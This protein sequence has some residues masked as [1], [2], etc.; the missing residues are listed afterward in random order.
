MKRLTLIISIIGC[1]LP[2]YV[3]GTVIRVPEDHPTIQSGITA[4]ENGN[5]VLVNT[6]VYAGT[7]NRNLTFEGKII[8]VK[9]VTGP[10]STIIDCEQS[11]R[12][13]V[14]DSQ[15][16]DDAEFIGF[17]ISNGY[18]NSDGAG[19]HCTYVSPLIDNCI[20]K[21]CNA[22]ESG[23]GI[24][25]NNSGAV[26][27][28]NTIMGN[29]SDYGGGVAMENC[30]N[31]TVSLCTITEN[32]AEDKGGGLYLFE[33]SD[34][35]ITACSIDGNSSN[36]GGGISFKETHN[37]L[38]THNTLSGNTHYGIFGCLSSFQ[39]VNCLL[40]HNDG[41]VSGWLMAPNMTNVTI[42]DHTTLGGINLDSCN[43]NI[44][45]SIVWDNEPYEITQSAAP[46][47]GPPVPTIAYSDIRGGQPGPGNIDTDPLFI[48]GSEWEYFLS[49][50][51]S[52]QS[53]NSPCVDTGG[54]PS[55]EICF[56]LADLYLCMDQL[57]TSTQFHFDTGFVDM[58]AHSYMPHPTWTPGPT[59]F[60]TPTPTLP[61]YAGTRL[62]LPGSPFQ[63][64]DLVDLRAESRGGD[65]DYSADLA[66]VLDVYGEYW[67][68]PGWSQSF[69]TARIQ[70]DPGTATKTP[71][72][73]FLWPAGNFGS[74]F[75]LNFWGVIFRP[76]TTQIIGTYDR[77]TFGYM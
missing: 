12:G 69:D 29:S 55:A 16:S 62:S 41:G 48:G 57:S 7:G 54:D 75:G 33:T 73:T 13:L 32:S 68:Y 64:G 58:G 6:G 65:T 76:E 67:F 34:V 44:R 8:T 2:G 77:V 51:S 38:L 26:L 36:L 46:I 14:F 17:T 56:Q 19:I 45:N 39:M 1:F 18:S 35:F 50:Q 31:A 52:G 10:I 43:L 30:H 61:P 49:Q 15:D 25:L 37:L 5:T 20:I 53:D 11:S 72:L 42:A 9:S 70:L 4:A 60:P 66:V 21:D 28:T 27:R 22:G 3:W 47:S 24:Y 74:A 40:D 23:G 63:A 59:P 71:V